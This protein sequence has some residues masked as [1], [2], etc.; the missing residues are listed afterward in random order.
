MSRGLIAILIT[1]IALNSVAFSATGPKPGPSALPSSAKAL[2]VM[3]FNIMCDFCSKGRDN[4]TFVERLKAVADTINRH[5]PDL[6][7]LQELRTGGQ[8]ERLLTL[9]HDQYTPLFAE[10][11]ALSYADP[12]LLVRTR[13][14]DVV[15][16]EGLWLGPRTPDF[17][18]GWKTSFPRRI[19]YVTL[20]DKDAGGEIIF[21][22]T[23]FD[24]NPRNREP[25]A[26]LL[27]RKFAE[28]ETPFIFAGDT[29]L[30]PDRAGYAA[31]AKGFRDSYTEV[32][33]HP[34]ISNGATVSSDGCNLEKAPD[35]PAC[36][37]D[38]I[39]LSRKNP[40]KT[41]RWM[42]DAFRYP[43]MKGFISD[44]RA[45]IVELSR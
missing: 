33:H 39:F 3:T 34:Y 22:G 37:V 19:E 28:S 15:A 29:N 14:F 12:T 21:A 43:G 45:V 8:V 42:L 24:N 4:G 20:K 13:R 17:G 44:H 25:S 11:Y 6:I 1:I 7:S 30:R 38:H 40:W 36:R 2:R 23:H 26:E 35:F 9:L 18:L 5:D 16:K 41:Q 27:I 10:G 32:L 31:L